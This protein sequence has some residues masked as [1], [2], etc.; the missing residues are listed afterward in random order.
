MVVLYVI[1]SVI[2]AYLLGAIPLSYLVA[3]WR[4]GFDIRQVGSRNMGAMNTFYNVGIVWG[5]LVLVFDIGKGSLAVAAADLLGPALGMPEGLAFWIQLLAGLTVVL[6]HAYPVFLGFRGG[7][8][9][10]SAIGA[11]V[12]L[13]PM[14]APIYLGV[15]LLLLLITRVPT[16]SYGLA[17]F[18]APVMAAF[19]PGYYHWQYVVYP[20]VLVLLPAVKY[21]PR[22]K[23]MRRKAGSWRAVFLRKRV[24]ERY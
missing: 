18:S 16:V 9:G 19:W 23:E 7:K 15:F 2:I 13:M 4:K 14:L 22:L 24:Q 10:A 3:R 20:F 11:L 21:I 8:G 5:L 6:G 1:L 17:F 12:Y